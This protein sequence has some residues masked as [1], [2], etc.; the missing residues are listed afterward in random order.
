MEAYYTL[1]DAKVQKADGCVADICRES[2]RH[3][4]HLRGDSQ[5]HVAF[6]PLPSP[7]LSDGPHICG[8]AFGV[9]CSITNHLSSFPLSLPVSLPL[10]VVRR[11]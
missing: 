7:R 4:V 9:S 6:Y 3:T 5:V 2:I 1:F 8:S 11:I 10:S